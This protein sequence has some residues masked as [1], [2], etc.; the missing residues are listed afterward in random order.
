MRIENLDRIAGIRI[1]ELAVDKQ[2]GLKAYARFTHASF[3]NVR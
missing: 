2:L 1:D 3:N